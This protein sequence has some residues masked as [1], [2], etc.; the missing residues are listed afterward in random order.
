VHDVRS[1]T[2]ST[3]E[4]LHPICN[5]TEYVAHDRHR[6]HKLAIFIQRCCAHHFLFIENLVFSLVQN[7]CCW[8][9]GNL[10]IKEN[11]N[12]NENR[13]RYYYGGVIILSFMVLKDDIFS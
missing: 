7:F 8:T 3:F 12:G 2:T 1:V 6:T 5:R 11:A 4:I 9:C 13:P 10:S